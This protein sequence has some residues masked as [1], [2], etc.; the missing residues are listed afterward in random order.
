[1]AIDPPAGIS[2]AWL[3]PRLRM[4]VGE[5]LSIYRLNVLRCL[6][7]RR[8]VSRSRG[9]GGSSS[10]LIFLNKRR[11]RSSLAIHLALLTL[12]RIRA[13]IT[14]FTIIPAL[15]LSSVCLLVAYYCAVCTLCTLC[16]LPSVYALI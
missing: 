12:P 16:V 4:D 7:V 13:G 9:Q 5:V 1:M 2:L 14:A 15:H 3:D 8:S 11:R 6:S 10:H